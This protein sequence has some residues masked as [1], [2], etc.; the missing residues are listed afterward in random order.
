M[1][2]TMTPQNPLLEF[3]CR[4]VADYLSTR[5]SAEPPG[6]WFSLIITSWLQSNRARGNT[7]TN[8]HLGVFNDDLVYH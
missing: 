4:A 3:C 1:L 7:M 5:A 6:V 2:L 8:D